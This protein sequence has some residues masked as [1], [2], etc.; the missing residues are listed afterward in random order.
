MT[1]SADLGLPPE[2]WKPERDLILSSRDGFVWASWQDTEA[3]VRLGRQDSVAA[4]MEDF[5]AQVALGSTF[6]ERG[7][8]CH[9]KD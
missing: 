2:A 5:L 1:E 4:I 6:Q 7:S 8:S 9:Y 3:T